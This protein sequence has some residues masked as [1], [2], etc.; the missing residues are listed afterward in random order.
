MPLM[1]LD[2]TKFGITRSHIEGCCRSHK[3]TQLFVER[4]TRDS[5]IFHKYPANVLRKSPSC[6][7]ALRSIRILGVTSCEK[8]KI[9]FRRFPLATIGPNRGITFRR[10]LSHNRWLSLLAFFSLRGVTSLV[11]ENSRTI[12]FVCA[13]SFSFTRWKWPSRQYRGFLCVLWPVRKEFSMKP[14]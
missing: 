5:L 6:W 2:N 7:N 9:S 4:A 14:N 11:K 1:R 10:R 8:M 12:E 3:V 13:V